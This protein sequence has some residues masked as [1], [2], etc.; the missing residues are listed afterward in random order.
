MPPPARTHTVAR[1]L[2]PYRYLCHAW[3][4]L[5]FDGYGC[6]L[7]E[8]IEF[9]P[10][11]AERTLK[12]FRGQPALQRCVRVWSFYRS[13]VDGGRDDYGDGN[14]GYGDA[15]GEEGVEKEDGEDAVAAVREGVY[16][17]WTEMAT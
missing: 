2:L 5:I 16:R 12:V 11:D 14:D 4:A 1:L 17:V 15:G 13:E 9:A 8:N 10:Q 3:A 7:F 6:P